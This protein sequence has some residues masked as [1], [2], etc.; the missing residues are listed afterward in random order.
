MSALHMI[1]RLDTGDGKGHL[2]TF[3]TFLPL[4]PACPPLIQAAD[5]ITSD[6]TIPRY[7]Y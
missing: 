6:A 5:I 4:N 2:F 3:S 7:H 1:L